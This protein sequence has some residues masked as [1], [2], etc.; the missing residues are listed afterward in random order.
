MDKNVGRR[1]RKMVRERKKR[2]ERKREIFLVFRWS[3]FNGSRR[4]VDPRNA[5][6]TW[7][8]KSWSFVKLHEEENFS[9]WNIYILKAI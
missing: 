5:G 4:K 8:L 7:V 6:Y 9:T 2:G 1:E 3:K